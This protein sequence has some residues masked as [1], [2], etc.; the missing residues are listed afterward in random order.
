MNSGAILE[1]KHRIVK[2]F[3][4]FCFATILPGNSRAFPL[5]TLIAII[6]MFV[7]IVVAGAAG[8]RG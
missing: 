3:S 1:D 5:M 2:L 8:A 4:L 7:V 6:V